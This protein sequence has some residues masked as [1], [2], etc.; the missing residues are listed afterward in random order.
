MA[1]IGT[2]AGLAS[3]APTWYEYFFVPPTWAVAF[4]EHRNDYKAAYRYGRC[5]LRFGQ[6]PSDFAPECSRT[7]DAAPSAPLILLWGD[8]HAAHLY[9]G[10]SE[11]QR[12]PHRSFGLAQLTA[13]NCPPIFE[14]A[15]TVRPNCREVVDDVERKI[16]QL[17]PKVAII[18]GAWS[19]YVDDPRA[20]LNLR[21]LTAT[22]KRLYSLGVGHVIVI[23][24]VPRWD[25]PLPRLLLLESNTTPLVPGASPQYIRNRLLKD[26]RDLDSR[27][28]QAV[29]AGGGRFVSAIDTLC[30]QGRGCLAMVVTADGAEPTAWDQ[31]HLTSAGSTAFIEAIW[32]REIEP[33]LAP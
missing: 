1:G 9:P 24:P 30:D 12:R 33:E 10:L 31:D 28:R 2:V 21:A 16:P 13:A 18:A 25:W 7:F 23:G 15:I 29:V 5:L 11:Q 27:I 8:S 3:F 14:V 20:R 17:S 26:T 19:W 6:N 4:D 32:K 22:V